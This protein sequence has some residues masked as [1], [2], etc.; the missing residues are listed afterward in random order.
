MNRAQNINPRILTWARETAGLSM[1]DAAAKLGLTNSSKASAEEKLEKL[2]NG[3]DKPTRLQ[4]MKIA[5]TYRRP[6]TAFYMAAPPATG[7]RGED[8]RTLP[9][10]VAPQETATLDALLRDVRARQ[11]MLRSILEDEDD[12]PRLPFVGSIKISSGIADAVVRMKSALGVTDDRALRRG[13]ST[14]DQLFGELRHRVEALGVFVLLAGNLGTFHS[15]ISEKVFRGFAIA[16][17]VAP[18][19]VINDQDA[20]AARS[21]TL[22]H[23][24]S[25]IFIG[26]SG[27]SGAPVVGEPRTPLAQI[28]RFCNDVAGEFLLPTAVL[29]ETGRMTDATAAVAQI[30]ATADV[31]KVS[32]AMVAYRFWRTGRIADSIYGEVVTI[33]AARWAAFR[34]RTREQNRAEDGQGPSYYTVRKHRL[35]EALLR[36]VGQTLRSNELTHTKAGKLLGVKASSV[37]PLLAGVEGLGSPIVGKAG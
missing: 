26:S 24:L 6:L 33:Y 25:H 12:T 18:L 4:L 13:V 31:W 2:E 16:D 37:E 15:N 5:N 22:I 28:E 9:G 14:P 30:S 29:P 34:E 36:L 7:S 17:K 19:I 3:D 23:E 10:P 11:D 21:F 1:E 32:E 35:G 20:K 27:I 8:F